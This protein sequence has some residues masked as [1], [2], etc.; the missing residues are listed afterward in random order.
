MTID[1]AHHGPLPGESANYAT[2]ARAVVSAKD[3]RAVGRPLPTG[4]EWAKRTRFG[5]AVARVL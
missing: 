5:G 1:Y 2:N 4:A 3:R